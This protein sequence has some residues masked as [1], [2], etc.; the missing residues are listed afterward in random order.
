MGL[1][2]FVRLPF[3]FSSSGFFPVCLSCHLIC[4]VIWF[5]H[6][7]CFC[8]GFLC[9]GPPFSFLS[10]FSFLSVSFCLSFC[11]S[12]CC[13]SG[14]VVCFVFVICLFMGFWFL[15]QAAFLAVCFMLF[16]WFEFLFLGVF[17]VL[18]G[19]VLYFVSLN[20]LLGSGFSCC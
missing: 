11:L 15:H 9:G 20:C 2:F 10:L 7:I 5:C 1:C 19:F 14:F 8:S 3:G 13:L 16:S 18:S 4:F 6:L 17:T 12:F